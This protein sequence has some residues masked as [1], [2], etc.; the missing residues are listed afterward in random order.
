M[1]GE[2]T[3]ALTIPQVLH[4]RSQKLVESGLFP[5]LSDV[6]KYGLRRA[7]ADSAKAQESRVVPIQDLRTS[8]LTLKSPLYV[9]VEYNGVVV[10]NSNDLDIF[11]YGD[12]EDKAIGDFCA[13]VVETYWALKEEQDNLGPHLARIWRYLSK[14]V[15]EQS[16]LSKPQMTNVAVP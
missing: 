13:C 2:T 11:G 3:I 4:Q 14:W 8:T 7:L 1:S 15:E 6:V 12:I 5:N 9:T 10:V 16:T